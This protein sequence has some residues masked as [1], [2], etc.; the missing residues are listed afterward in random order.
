M[1]AADLPLWIALPVGLLLVTGAALTAIGTIGL[2]RFRTFY[3]RV[4]APTLGTS[5]GTACIVTASLLFFSA[6]GARLAIHELLIGFF[7]VMTAPVSLTL[8]ARAALHRDR[9][10]G[11]EPFPLPRR[12][13]P[14]PAP[15]QPA[16]ASALIHTV[17]ATAPASGEPSARSPR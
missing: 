2:V 12:A 15:A 14:P 13:P 17:A 1:S 5:Y 9:Q 10:E 6:S 7:I 16:D 11:K 4:H 3:E 8:V